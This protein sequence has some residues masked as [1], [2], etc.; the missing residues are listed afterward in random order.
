M[1]SL[2]LASSVILL[3]L[4]L[5]LC[6]EARKLENGGAASR[7]GQHEAGV[8]RVN[9]DQERDDPCLTVSCGRGRR[10]HVTEQGPTCICLEQCPNR[11]KPV[12]GTD[13]MIYP[14]HCHLH[15]RACVDKRHIGPLKMAAC[16]A[17]PDVTSNS[18]AAETRKASTVPQNNATASP[19][20]TTNQSYEPK[21][22]SIDVVGAELTTSDV[23]TESDVVE[24]RPDHLCSLHKFQK[25]KD[26]LL[27]LSRKQLER[28]GRPVGREYVIS[29]LFSQYDLNN[30]GLLETA[31]LRKV[32][33]QH[34]L[35]DLISGC[36]LTD[37]SHFD[38]TSGDGKLDI[39]EFY[40]AFNKLYSIAM[41][42][43]D[44]SLEVN[45]LSALVGDNVEIK[46][47]VTGSP[48]PRVVWRRSGRELT[49]LQDEALRVFP[50]GSLY[51]SH[52][53][54]IHA[55]N[56]TCHA[57]DNAEVLQTHV[58]NVQTPPL[59][60]VDRRLQN[61]GVGQMAHI[62]CHASGIPAPQITW[63]KN[64][65]PISPQA[66]RYD[67]T[68]GGSGL[69]I[70]PLTVSDTGAYMCEASNSA[71]HARAVSSLLVQQKAQPDEPTDSES[72]LMLFHD[73]GISVYDPSSCRL[74]HQIQGSDIIPG[75][76]DYVCGGLR[77]ACEWGAAVEV[78][79]VYVYVTQPMLQRVLLISRRQL[80]VVDVVSTDELPVQLQYVPHL[81]QVWVLNWRAAGNRGVRTV[82]VIRNASQKRRHF[83]VHLQPIN[84]HVDLVMN[85]LVPPSELADQKFRYAFV[86]HSNHRGMYKVDMKTL[87]FVKSVDLTPY[88]CVPQKAQFARI[89]G[90]VVIS[91]M[92]PVTSR[93]S[94][95]LLYDQ[96]TDSVV[97][98]Q[99]S[100]IG[101]PY[102]TPDSASCVTVRRGPV[103]TLAVQRLNG[104][105][106]VFAFDVRT[107]LNISDVTFHPSR[108]G[109]GYDLYATAR[110]VAEVMVIDLESGQVEILTSV[111]GGS[112][113]EPDRWGRPE[114]PLNS[115]GR[116]Q[117]H[118]AAA[119]GDTLLVLNGR[120]HTE[121]CRVAGL[122]GLRL[123]IWLQK[124]ADAE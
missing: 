82:Q 30:N 32:T 46:C 6:V 39:N 118:L 117:C 81:D 12:C 94:G 71:G 33:E 90:F 64:E 55:G 60:E 45:L 92:E 102:L 72:Q 37:L 36:D 95:Q 123:Q 22:P 41:V 67:V 77:R 47:D 106:L 110:G 8:T 15:R 108:S 35:N 10:C 14:N 119:D 121:N 76:Q 20:T 27:Q 7:H 68:A 75:T 116:F 91:C 93:P 5:S 3:P 97:S 13:G 44:K 54:L 48:A 25:M 107:P 1:T 34:H 103:T 115:A 83:T 109:H 124:I 29:R 50:D 96:L 63:L 112:L 40:I 42:S 74:E 120:T 89:Y 86:T 85:M 18:S 57:R 79:G 84:D 66:G 56:Y 62:Q 17:P 65:T 111:G 69:L 87:N 78:A 16:L 31:E 80:L 49:Q 21:P 19:R 70:G 23:I 2:R 101:E 11:Y 9:R 100:L 98:A 53:Q 104:D 73:W 26:A 113:S 52:V 58:L 43:L 4:L 88:N 28:D 59:S 105:G 114:R 99:P 61:K 122:R 24:L 51:L 38:D